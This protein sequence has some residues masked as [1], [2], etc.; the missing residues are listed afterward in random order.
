MVIYLN[1]SPVKLS[2][3]SNN[4]AAKSYKSFELADYTIYYSSRKLRTM[5][6]YRPPPSTSNALT[7]NLFF[8][9]FSHLLESTTLIIEPILICGDFNFH[10]DINEDRP[11][12]RFC[13]I[14]DTFNFQ[15]HVKEETHKGGHTLDLII[16]RSDGLN[17]VS[18]IHVTDPGISDRYA[19]HCALSISKPSYKRKEISYRSISRIDSVKFVNDIKSSPL[20]NFTHINNIEDL[21]NLYEDTLMSILDQHAPTKRRTITLRPAAPW[22][23]ND[24][25][26]EKT[27][28][29]RLERQWRKT[30]LTIHRQLY[31]EQCSLVSFVS[32]N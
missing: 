11:A 17:L 19:V 16:T 25:K 26:V 7:L 32:L 9:E 29:R 18:D 28:R 27:K 6:I 15:Q 1:T 14:L 4:I 2:R 13:E 3:I 21:L 20:N 24:I 8:E 10:L 30:R 22:Y 5:V 23:T 31:G 12:Q